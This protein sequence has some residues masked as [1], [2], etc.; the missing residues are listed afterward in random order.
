MGEGFSLS[1]QS[2]FLV[3]ENS[4]AGAAGIDNFLK[5]WT[6]NGFVDSL[7]GRLHRT[8]L[9]LTLLGHL[10]AVE[11]QALLSSD[12]VKPHLVLFL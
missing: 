8:D 10:H 7:N 2:L 12:Y 9:S 3:Y 5:D 11:S 6:D 1:S 4:Q